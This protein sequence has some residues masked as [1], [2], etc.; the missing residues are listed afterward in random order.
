MDSTFV[1]QLSELLRTNTAL[2]E[3]DK[4][5]FARPCSQLADMEVYENSLVVKSNALLFL[6][7]RDKE[8]LL[9]IISK[10]GIA[11]FDSSLKQIAGGQPIQL[12]ICPINPTNTMALQ[13]T[14]VYTLPAV[15]GLK[16]SV[17][18]GDRLGLATPGHVRA[19]RQHKMFPI[20]AQQSIREMQRTNRTPAQVIQDAVW[21]VFQE[22]WQ[23]GFGADA[24]HLKTTE[25]ID[26]CAEAGFTFYTIDPSDYVDDAADTDEH[27]VL[28]KKVASLPWDALQT[29]L[30]ETEKKYLNQVVKTEY[31]ETE[32]NKETLFRA[33][34]KYGRAIAHTAGLF[35]HLKSKLDDKPFELEMSVDETGT[36]TSILEHFFI[37]SQLQRLDVEWASLAPRF[38]G[39]FEKGVDFIGEQEQFEATFTQHLSIAKL[40]E[41]YK[42][43]L[44]SGSD[45]FSIYPFIARQAGDLIHLK[46]AGT[47]YLEALRVVAEH[48]P[49]L[50]SEIFAYALESYPNDRISYHVSA[51]PTQLE[52]QQ[53]L[54]SDIVDQ[55]DYRQMLHV[56]FGSVLTARRADGSTRFFTRL[57]KTLRNHEESYAQALELHIGKH[58]TPFDEY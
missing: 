43:S 40:F 32:F 34:A 26:R 30:V 46:T 58:L 1:I 5:K 17:G 42:L 27:E 53:S 11:D 45:K 24:D 41:P 14:L 4:T 10:N 23:G 55:F 8:K 12:Q 37:A 31:F 6:G 20:F 52:D 2:L 3:V 38:S 28:Q 9:G 21:G 56:T 48:D 50:F 16:K 35:R 39:K 47:S 36:P 57:L 51:Q 29:S 44:H 7:R 25:D 18:L 13:K 33:A 15:V 49:D 19:V 54:N 22:G